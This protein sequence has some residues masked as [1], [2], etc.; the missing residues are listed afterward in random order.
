MSEADGSSLSEAINAISESGPLVQHLTTEVT[1]R[2]TAN[3][4][5]QWVGC[6]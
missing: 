6:R 1:M 4:T 5:L 3:V 2:E